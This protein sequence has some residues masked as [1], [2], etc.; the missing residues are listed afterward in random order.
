[1]SANV[2]N[3]NDVLGVVDSKMAELNSA[4][5]RLDDL[6]G[7][8]AVLI[9]SVADLK[10][11]E[12]EHLRNDDADENA[13]VESL[14]TLRGR[15]DVQ[16]ARASSLSS[17]IEEQKATVVSV[18]NGFG[19]AAQNLFSQLLAHRTATATRIFDDHFK[20]PYSAAFPKSHLIEESKLVRQTRDLLSPRFNSIH[21][22]TD[23]RISAL[24]N[25]GKE[26]APLRDALTTEPDLM[27]A[28][29]HTPTLSVVSKAA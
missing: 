15:I 12:T 19:S 7:R 20:M 16:T 4:L 23:D 25:L 13:V 28:P 24:R 22:P 10:K 27:L 17:Q 26:Y 21:V 1:M 14:T 5:A 18:G 3:N 8:R 11:Q 29:V 2:T 9:E 6:V